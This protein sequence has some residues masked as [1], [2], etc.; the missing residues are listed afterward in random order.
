MISR[1]EELAEAKVRFPIGRR[2]RCYPLTTHLDWCEVSIRSKPYL[3]AWG[4]I[5]VCVQ[6]AGGLFIAQVE[7]LKVI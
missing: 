6:G 3:N 4:E 1:E 7:R 2:V 5:L